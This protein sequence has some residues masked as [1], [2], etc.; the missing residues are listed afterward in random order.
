MSHD[1][2]VTPRG[3]SASSRSWVAFASVTIFATL[4]FAGFLGANVG[5]P[6]DLRRVGVYAAITLGAALLPI[7]VAVLTAGPTTA[8]RLGLVISVFLFLFFN[9]PVTTSLQE[10][11]SVPDY[12][13]PAGW[14]VVAAV[15]LVPT[16]ILSHRRSVQTYVALTGAGLLLFPLGQMVSGSMAGPSGEVEI[17]DRVDS[18]PGT[19]QERTQPNVYYFVPDGYPSLAVVESLTGMSM[20]GFRQELQGL[21]FHISDASL[22]N[23]PTTFASVSSTL[24]MQYLLDEGQD[25]DSGA[26]LK[27]LQGQNET[28]AEF[29]ERGY[30]YV[31]AYPGVWAGSRCS[32]VEHLCLGGDTTFGETDHALLSLTPLRTSPLLG[33]QHPTAVLEQTSDPLRIAEAAIQRVD[34]RPLFV[35]AHLLTPHPPFN[36][37]ASCRLRDDVEFEISTWPDDQTDEFGEVVTCLNQRLV[38]AVDR[39]LEDDPDPLIVIQADHGSAF[40]FTW[41]LDGDDW[42]ERGGGRQRL[43]ILSAI[44]FPQACHRIDI[45]DDLTPVNTFRLVF[46]CVDGTTPELLPSRSYLVRYHGSPVERL[47]P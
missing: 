10:A 46:A 5:E 34:R 39:I 32:G 21:G 31:H 8:R 38:Q 35:F 25:A 11:V 37:D 9:Y 23:Y 47:D 22:A 15:V 14:A 27:R 44:R 36:L 28:V 4:P 30:A 29:Q 12:L 7:V 16:L 2:D 41:E 26:L 43:S 20:S 24:D 40:D 17:A 3:P 1:D 45:P 13:H 6:I 33:S 18:A 42:L 19:G